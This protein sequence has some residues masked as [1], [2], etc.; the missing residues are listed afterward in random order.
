M[1]PSFGVAIDRPPSTSAAGSATRVARAVEDAFHR[2]ERLHEL[3]L[4][5]FRA[6]AVNERPA[7]RS[8]FGDAVAQ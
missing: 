8:A 1:G 2:P 7:I 3:E 5:A 4:L 6:L